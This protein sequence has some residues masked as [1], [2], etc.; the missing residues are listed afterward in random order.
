M[1]LTADMDSCQHNIFC[2]AISLSEDTSNIIALNRKV[3][4]QVKA[5]P[6]HSHVQDTKKGDTESMLTA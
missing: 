1:F 5:I 4:H 3:P 6:C 2:N